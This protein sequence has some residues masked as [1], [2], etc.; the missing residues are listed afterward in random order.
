MESVNNS[1]YFSVPLPL[2]CHGQQLQR[3][4]DPMVPPGPAP[5]LRASTVP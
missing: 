5:N 1:I 2:V 4:R 3:V